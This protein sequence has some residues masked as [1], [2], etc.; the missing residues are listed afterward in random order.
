MAPRHAALLV[1][2]V[3]AVSA[4][5]IL[6][7]LAEAPPLATG[8][9]RNAMAAAIVVPLVLVRHRG[10]LRALTGRQWAVAV[11]SGAVLA[12]HFA[13]WIPSLDYTSVAAS[14][15]LVTTGPVWVA[16]LSRITIGER[17]TRRAAIGIGLSLA[18]AIVISGADFGASARSLFGD[19]LALGAAV[20]A[21]AYILAGRGLR[22]RVSLLMYVG[23][24]YTVASAIL[25]LA[26]LVT[27]TPFAGYEPEVWGLFA[28][29]TLGP[30]ILGH[31]VFNYLLAHVEA[32]VVAI[33]VT[34]EPVGAS[35]M[36]LVLFAE[37][38]SVP[39]IAGG[40]LILAG[41][42]VAVAA[43]ARARGDASLPRGPARL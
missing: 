22:P 14:T 2:G 13:L 17:V 31:T 33:A 25:G 26:M 38:P 24:V 40:A 43:Q 20:A 37:A 42:Y 39:E 10:E 12:A 36:A 4:S 1:L 35:L 18:G 8:F 11:L 29:M 9:Y 15:V 21:A 32:S 6:I 41:I 7:R 28:L 16:L 5:A 34:A 23:I 27:G 3:L 30:Q 19:L